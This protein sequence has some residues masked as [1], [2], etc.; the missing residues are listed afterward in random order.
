MSKILCPSCYKNP[1]TK[2]PQFGIPNCDECNDRQAKL[3]S[4]SDPVEIIPERIK[5][6]RQERQDSIEQSHY[7]GELNKRWVDL[8]G[9]QAALDKGFTK[10]EIKNAKYVMDR[11]R[12][13]N[14]GI[15]Y[16]NKGF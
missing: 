11:A 13:K 6:E 9:E 15:S 5:L 3:L 1:V 7:K 12:D 10:K 2:H 8:W 4:P 16:Y 14:T